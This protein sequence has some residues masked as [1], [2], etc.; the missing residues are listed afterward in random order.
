M[1]N[2][3]CVIHHCRHPHDEPGSHQPPPVAN[4]LL[5]KE[6]TN[7]DVNFWSNI[8]YECPDGQYF[9]NWDAVIIYK[10]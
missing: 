5:L 6:R 7:W 10:S 4:S 8:Q 2:L 3:V 9:E 1:T